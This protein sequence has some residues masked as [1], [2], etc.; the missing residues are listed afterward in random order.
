MVLA[1]KTLDR[2]HPGKDCLQE[3]GVSVTL[4]RGPA[5]GTTMGQEPDRC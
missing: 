4:G 2:L 3:V 1:R 5:K